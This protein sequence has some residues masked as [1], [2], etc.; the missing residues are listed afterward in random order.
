VAGSTLLELSNRFKLQDGLFI[1][2]PIHGSLCL[3]QRIKL[4]CTQLHILDL[5]HLAGL[6]YLSII[7]NAI[8]KAETIQLADVRIQIQILELPAVLF[9]QF[10]LLSAGRH[11]VDRV[12]VADGLLQRKQICRRKVTAD[13][14]VLCNVRASVHNASEAAHNHELHA[15]TDQPFE[16]VQKIAAHSRLAFRSFCEVFSAI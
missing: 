6:L 9:R 15:A 13:V 4:Q 14:D 16:K 10:E 11:P 12:Q 7:A 3:Y 1:T 8:N 2:R 5:D